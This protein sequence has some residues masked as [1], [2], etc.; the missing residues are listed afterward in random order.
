MAIDPKLIDDETS[1]P[2]FSGQSSVGEFNPKDYCV[3]YL[4][5][6]LD[7]PSQV[8]E[9]QDLETRGIRGEGIILVSRKEFIFQ[10]NVYMLVTYYEKVG[11]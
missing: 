8:T 9:L 11:S 2:G 6:D 7:D 4:K 10:S 1:I 3:R 5:A